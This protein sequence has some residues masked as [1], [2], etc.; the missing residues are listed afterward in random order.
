ML[1]GDECSTLLNQDEAGYSVNASPFHQPSTD[2]MLFHDII[3]T[4]STVQRLRIMERKLR[5]LNSVP[6]AAD[7]R[8]HCTAWQGLAT[9]LAYLLADFDHKLQK[10]VEEMKQAHEHVS[11]FKIRHHL[12]AEERKI[13]LLAHLCG[14]CVCCSPMLA[15]SSPQWGSS[16]ISALYN[17]TSS[18]MQ[19]VSVQRN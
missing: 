12:E 5:L 6:P 14:C 10:Y 9:S 17:I 18:L 1:L 3:A 2:G 7:A 15:P 11:L 4:A 19:Q 8:T 16:F 13:C